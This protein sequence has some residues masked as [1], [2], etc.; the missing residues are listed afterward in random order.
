MTPSPTA[1]GVLGMIRMTGY[2][3]PARAAMRAMVRPA[4]IVTRRKR[5][6]RSA[7]T[8]PISARRSA[9]I[10]GLTPR[11]MNLPSLAARSAGPAA[12]PNSAARASAFS[13]VRLE[14]K[15]CSGGSFFT[16]ARASAPPMFPTPMK[17]KV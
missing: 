3:P 8:G 10:W 15:T 9:I 6:V 14:R 13:N 17:E 5:S 12:Q 7:R 16:A 11:K 4:A 2:S 1:Q